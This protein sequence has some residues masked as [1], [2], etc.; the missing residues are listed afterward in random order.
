MLGM[1]AERKLASFKPLLACL[2]AR[3]RLQMSIKDIAKKKKRY[4]N[5][6]SFTEENDSKGA[7]GKRMCNMSPRK[8]IGK[9]A[10]GKRMCKCPTP[11]RRQRINSFHICITHHASHIP[12]SSII[13][14]SLYRRYIHPSSIV[15]CTTGVRHVF[16][17]VAPSS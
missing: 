5:F 13:Y 12:H 8:T 2:L 14:C 9:G 3:K 4:F 6:V 7:E 10:E 16:F 15:R 1:D 17:I 11:R